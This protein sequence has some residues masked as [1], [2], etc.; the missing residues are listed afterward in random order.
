MLHLDAAVGLAL[1]L[2]ACTSRSLPPPPGAPPPPPRPKP[3]A[4]PPPHR[5]QVVVASAGD[6]AV[7]DPA[8]GPDP[9]EADVIV[10]V[11]DRLVQLDPR[12]Q[13]VPGLATSWRR[14]GATAWE[15][16]LRQGVR[17]SNG[18]PFEAATVAAW[19]ERLRTGGG[20]EPG[21]RLTDPLPSV[22]R[23]QR[24]DDYTV[25]FETREPDPVLPRQLAK[26]D[27]SITPRGP[28]QS[29]DAKALWS[30]PVGTGPYVV[31]DVVPG[32]HVTLV[33]NGGYWSTPPKAGEVEI[34]VMPDPAERAAALKL[35]AVD[36][37]LALQLAD[38]PAVKDTPPLEVPPVP[39]A[40]RTYRAYL[41]TVAPGPLADRRVRQALNYAVD[42]QAIVDGILSGQAVQNASLTTPQSFG[43]CPVAEYP[44]DPARASALL[45]EAGVQGVALDLNYVLADEAVV[46][47][48]A[49]YLRAVGIE[50]RL[51]PMSQEALVDQAR[52]RTLRGLW[53]MGKADPSLDA[54]ASLRD[55][56]EDGLFGWSAPLE[57]EARR[58][59]QQEREETR[60][61]KRA[62]MACAIQKIEHDEAPVVFLWQRNILDGLNRKTVA[63]PVP[64]DGLLHLDRLTPVA[65]P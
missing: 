25:R 23:V 59:F 15:L 51:S 4:P 13:L 42:K 2:T 30:R 36:V 7:L 63:W 3:G 60:D 34:R 38:V 39:E 14:L 6:M 40:S 43:Y 45:Q 37:A 41:N 49:R 35:G 47:A 53:Y 65:P 28:F 22:T 1:L 16:S 9:A 52:A 46:Q 44:Y 33:P 31:A 29:G 50:V 5:A 24:V 56:Q 18:E 10:N 20:Q 58:L 11:Y 21:R 32:H 64:S 57:G 12:L 26:P 17:F 61:A 62:E 8:F 48:I 55:F 27:A 54:D 19:F